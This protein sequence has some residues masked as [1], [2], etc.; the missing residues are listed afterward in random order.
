MPS[1]RLNPLSNTKGMTAVDFE[2]ERFDLGSK[3]GFMK[4]NVVKAL[5]HGEI[6]EEFKNYIKELAKT[7]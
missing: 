4:A 2:G 5:E 3:L 7:L 1:L 6:G